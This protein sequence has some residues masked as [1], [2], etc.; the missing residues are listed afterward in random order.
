MLSGSVFSFKGLIVVLFFLNH[1]AG[2]ET[3]DVLVPGRDI[4][5]TLENISVM[6]GWKIAQADEILGLPAHMFSVRGENPGEDNVVFYYANYIYLFWFRDRV[7]QVRVDERWPYEIRGIRMGMKRQNII[8]I[9]GNPVNLSD[10][11]LTWNIDDVGY[12]IQ[13]RLYFD[14]T[15][16]LVDFY[17]FRSDW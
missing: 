1:M 9:W 11:A 14:S 8:E 3:S 2:A 7:W 6:L 5:P 4:T 16:K 12:P 10:E 17:L 15:D 13:A